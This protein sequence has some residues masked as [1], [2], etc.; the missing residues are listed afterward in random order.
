MIE[1]GQQKWTILLSNQLNSQ[2]QYLSLLKERHLRITCSSKAHDIKTRK[3]NFEAL[4]IRFMKD[5]G[6]GK[7]TESML[8]GLT[9]EPTAESCFEKQTG[10]KVLDVGLIVC[11]LQPFLA[12][13]P[14][15]FI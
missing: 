9:M 11:L 5:K 10:W 12:C 3:E 2:N 7:L 13:F 4:A 8:H 14:D 15:G 1:V 6:K